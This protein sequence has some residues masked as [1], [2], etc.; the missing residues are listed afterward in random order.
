MGVATVNQYRV[1]PGKND[2]FLDAVRQTFALAESL[3]AKP[4]LRQTLIGGELSG[5]RSAIFQ[6]A[7]VPRPG[8][9]T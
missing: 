1:P 4:T 7:E 8:H 2:A 3:G 9:A 5:V 6:F